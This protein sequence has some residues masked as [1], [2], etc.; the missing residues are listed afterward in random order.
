MAQ[1]Y[2]NDIQYYQPQVTRE[3]EKID[4]V[5][6]SD[7][8][9]GDNEEEEDSIFDK[10]LTSQINPQ[11][12]GSSSLKEFLSSIG[13]DV[14]YSKFFNMGYETIEDLEDLTEE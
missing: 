1:G 4:K 6:A 2:Q 3:Q 13:L 7:S 12:K 9:G 5:F 11:N 8:E 14:V 10:P